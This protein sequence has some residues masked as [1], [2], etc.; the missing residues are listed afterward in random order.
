MNTHYLVFSTQARKESNYFYKPEE[1]S[2]INGMSNLVV[3]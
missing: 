3:R 2:V 1:N